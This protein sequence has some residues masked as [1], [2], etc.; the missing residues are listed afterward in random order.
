M[1]HIKFTTCAVWEV[2]WLWE[3]NRRLEIWEF[4]VFEFALIF[5]W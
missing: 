4:R 2:V 5:F 1:G 3:R